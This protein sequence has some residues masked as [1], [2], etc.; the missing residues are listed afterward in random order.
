MGSREVKVM[1]DGLNLMLFCY[2]W[3]V[4]YYLDGE[5]KENFEFLMKGKNYLET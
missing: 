5:Q 2:S 1:D 4:A 3:L